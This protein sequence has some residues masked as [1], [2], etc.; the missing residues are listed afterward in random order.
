[1]S[2]G[3]TERGGVILLGAV[4]LA[5]G[6]IVNS[7]LI[8]AVGVVVLAVGAVFGLLGAVGRP[9]AGRHYWY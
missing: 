8:W 3:T 2:A 1:M 7:Y 9:I 6:L 4:L 5:L